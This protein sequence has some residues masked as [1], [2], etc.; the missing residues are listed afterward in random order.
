[1]AE[2]CANCGSTFASPAELV[3][4]VKKK[5]RTVDPNESLAMNPES[6]QPGLVCALCGDQFPNREALARHNVR[7]HFRS[8]QTARGTST[9]TYS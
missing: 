4:H 1:V 7:P 8:N 3:F 9:Y 5:H 2:L 6:H